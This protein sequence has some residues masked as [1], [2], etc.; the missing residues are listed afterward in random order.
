M[1]SFKLSFIILSLLGIQIIDG[2]ENT[3][4]L[5]NSYNG[6]NLNDWQNLKSRSKNV[7]DSFSSYTNAYEYSLKCD[8]K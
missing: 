4:F 2:Y 6:Q 7:Q 8:L 1:S 5:P 3:E